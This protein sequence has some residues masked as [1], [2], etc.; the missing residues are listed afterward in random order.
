MQ[1]ASIRLAAIY[2]DMVGQGCIILKKNA[3]YMTELI[4][5]GVQYNIY[6]LDIACVRSVI[7]YRYR[8][9]VRCKQPAI[10]AAAVN[11]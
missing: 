8:Q 6:N 2:L 4:V 3:D 7:I 5:C 10:V 9:L 1:I 11:D